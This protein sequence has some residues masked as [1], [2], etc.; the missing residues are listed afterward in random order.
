MPDHPTLSIAVVDDD[1]AVLNSFRFM[2]E[3]AGFQVSTFASA[4]AFLESDLTR[5][6]CLILD[7]H[8]PVMT[9]LE[10]A[11]KLR[12]DGIGLPILLVTAAPSPG[13]R[14]RAAEL[15]IEQVIEKPPSEDELIRF[16]S[17]AGPPGSTTL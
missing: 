4:V 1:L 3:I 6:R 7:H 13:I 14:A 15:G 11:A 2:L 10:L 12:G 5:P 17:I 9:G 16:V 8:M